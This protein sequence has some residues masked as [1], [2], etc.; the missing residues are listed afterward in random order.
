M[1]ELFERHSID[2]QIA[3]N[4]IDSHWILEFEDK[5]SYCSK[6]NAKVKQSEGQGFKDDNEEE[7]CLDESKVD[8]QDVKQ[9]ELD[10]TVMRKFESAD[11]SH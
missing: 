5:V 1:L 6:L 7:D 9:E 2:F 11:V 10:R 4:I 8:V 3:S